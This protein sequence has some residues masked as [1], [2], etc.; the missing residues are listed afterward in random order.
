MIVDVC[1]EHI[2]LD[3]M[4]NL[5]RQYLFTVIA[6][7]CIKVIIVVITAISNTIRVKFITIISVIA[8]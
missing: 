6:F 3:F 7:V 4:I 8:K 2:T 5:F 1:K